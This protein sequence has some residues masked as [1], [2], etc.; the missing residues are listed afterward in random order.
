MVIYHTGPMMAGSGGDTQSR[1]NGP[2]V[3]LRADGDCGVE[4]LNWIGGGLR[5]L[6]CGFMEVNGDGLVDY[7]IDDGGIRAI[8]SSG[9]AQDHDV[10]LP[11]NQVPPDYAQHEA[12]RAIALPGPVGRIKD[13]LNAVCTGNTSGSQTYDI[14]Q[15]TAL[16][17]ITGDGI[18][19]YIYFGTRGA[20]ADG[21]VLSHPDLTGA[22]GN[23]QPGWWFMAGTGVGFAAPRAIRAPGDLPF[24][25]HISRERCDGTSSNVI[26]SLADI[27]GDGRP[28]LVWVVQPTIVHIS[29]IVDAAGQLGAHSAGQLVAIDNRFGSV[30]QITYGSAKS[31]PGTRQNVPFPQI[32]V[33]QIEQT[34]ELGLGTPLAP[35]RYAYGSPEFMYHPLLGRWIFNGYRRRIELI[36]EPA[37]T[38]GFVTGMAKI[39]DS[40]AVTELTTDADRFALA[41]RVRDV[42]YVTG[43]L[44]ADPRV[45]LPD[46]SL[47]SATGNQHATWRMQ[48]LPGNIPI[49]V[50]LEEECHQT[51]PPQSPG[52]FGDL[53]LC[54]RSLTPYVAERTAWEGND[55]YPS[56]DS[57]ATRT[58][59]TAVDG[60]GRPTRI[61]AEGDRVR[62]DDDFCIDVTYASQQPGAPFIAAA[63]HTQRVYDCAN[64]LR[65]FA[66]VRFLYDDLAEGLVGSG[67]PSGRI[68]ERYDV[69]TGTLLEQIPS[70]TL[71]RD[72]FG[73]PVSMTRTRPDGATS[74]TTLTYD[75]FGL[76]PI[77]T[78][79]TATG[80]A[81]P[82]IAQTTIYDPNTLLPL[83]TVDPNGTATHNTFDRFG[84]L[85]DMSVTLPGDNTTYL[86]VHTDFLR[87]DGAPGGREVRYRIYNRWTDQLSASTA[88]PSTVTTYTE[89]LDELGR[90]MHG[91]TNLGADYNDESLIVESV[92]YDGL[93][94]PVFA[95]DPFQST[96]FGPRYGT[97]FRYTAEGRPECLIEGLG[98]Q[99]VATTDE[100]E[101]RYPTCVSYVY[102]NGQL[103]VRTQGPNELAPSKPQTGAY[104]E[105]VLSATGRVLSR[106]RS[107]SGSL[108]EL[109]EYGYDALGALSS[110]RRWADPQGGTGAVTWSFANDSLG[111]VVT[112]SE[113]AGLTR[114]YTYDAWGRVATIGW[115]DST[116]TMAVQRGI[117]FQYDGLARLLRSVETINGEPQ[118]ARTKEY[119]YDVS[120]GRPQHLD[121]NYLLGQL[122]Y[123]RTPENHIFF[124]YDPLGRLTTLSRFNSDPAA[125]HAERA[126][127]G[128]S[129]QSETL[130]LLLPDTGHSPERIT[131]EYDSGQRLRAVNFQDAAGVSEIWRSLGTDAFGRVMKA[132]LGNGT[133]EH[134]TYRLDRRRELQSTRVDAGTRSREVFFRGYDGALL[135]KGTS[136]VNS[137]TNPTS[138]ETHTHYEYDAR[139]ALARAGVQNSSGWI[140]DTSYTYDGL[141]NLRSVANNLAASTLQIRPDAVDPDRICTIVAPDGPTAPCN[142]RYDATGNVRQVH[143]AAA[144]FTY[145][146]AD[147]LRSA[148]QGARQAQ[149]D[150]DAFGSI[151]SLTVRNGSVER[152]EQIYG[153]TS[154]NVGFFDSAG[155][156]ITIGDP[157]ATFQ[158]FIDRHIV[159][160]IGTLA[161]VRRPN[162]GQPV[163]LYPIGDYQGT[164]A[165]IGPGP[166]PTEAISYSPFGS[167]VTDSGNPNSL[168]WWPHQWNGGHVLDGFGLVVLGQRVLDPRTG[169][170]L[171]RDPLMR[172][173]TAAGANPY[174]FA[175]N[176]PVKF[177]DENGAEPT[178]D[179]GGMSAYARNTY[180]NWVR[181][182]TP[183][184]SI[185]I[186][187]QLTCDSGNDCT[188][189]IDVERHYALTDFERRLRAE[190]EEAKREG[191]RGGHVWDYYH[192]IVDDYNP[193]PPLG[194][195]LYSPAF[196]E[197]YDRQGNF[198]QLVYRAEGDT[199]DWLQP[200][201]FAAVPLAAAAGFGAGVRT[202]GAAVEAEVADEAAA[203]GMSALVRGSVPPWRY[204]YARS[205][206]PGQLGSTSWA[207]DITINPILK[208]GTQLLEETFLH[209]SVHRFLTPRVGLLVKTRQGW[210]KWWY[211]NSHLLRFTEEF[212]AYTY[213]TGSL[214]RAWALAWNPGYA[215][216]AGRLA[217]E[218]SVALGIYSGAF[219]GGYKL[220]EGLFGDTGSGSR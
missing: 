168:T 114:H 213:G 69:S 218:G 115:T 41:G 16:R 173:G 65:I 27:D 87:F 76:K 130:D 187:E 95:A 8:R 83:T 117:T 212:A 203:G 118:P 92:D 185:R 180:L 67:T 33:T 50:P 73:N 60:Y 217:I 122:S 183:A 113:P 165:V 172:A 127:F 144:L 48:P 64:N 194:Y 175:S 49:L 196:I 120:S 109:V 152:R 26:A 42:S 20:L 54:R 149:L 153:A 62:T 88:D 39:S 13:P 68:L 199:K 146:G 216:G 182:N 96:I 164:R 104:D 124:G 82:L 14:E 198:K 156:P 86:L 137:L 121:T 150:Y 142:Y 174:A 51:P 207:G 85:T 100:T 99:S 143:D 169:R 90:R 145:D 167:V 71:Q 132:K 208:P 105:E 128:P 219:Y 63:P 201:D 30:T 107:H 151:A 133:T 181:D 19:D 191:V 6:K 176:N 61:K 28:D 10:R 215:I 35:I 206:K 140:A 36:G 200:G 135:L 58:E 155:N 17:D 154:A 141:G 119:F 178:P 66:G 210:R 204:D 186:D 4:R 12:K 211:V 97:T 147:R 55:A 136:D 161:V 38:P 129:G 131:Y 21:T 46:V 134:H 166:S 24:A 148:E 7:V 177:I 43:F 93:G 197:I 59:I 47:S 125:Y 11:E 89:V 98:R 192:M 123:A 18:A 157:G 159:S 193:L 209:E 111:G 23:G 5:Q 2:P 184:P 52:I 1:W 162:S 126:A 77:R 195:A 72:T 158:K 106:S 179:L 94:R 188:T 116:G 25:L 101:D 202:A 57:V 220:N 75:P 84:R 44:S 80:L 205:W 78:E 171:Q 108:L 214:T 40:L 34:A 102:Q 74:T 189:M 9:L 15:Q 160:P 81:Q 37:S 56:T 31:D 163:T 139:N 79:T 91:I 53:V 112:M 70:G 110:I 190:T 170:F 29:K 22:D 138:I 32:V 3:T 103:L 45:L